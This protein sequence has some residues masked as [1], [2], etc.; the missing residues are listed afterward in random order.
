[1]TL[2][3]LARGPLLQASLIILVAGVIW[4]L[5][6]LV[7]LP[8]GRDHS[9]P[10]SRNLLGGAVYTI[11]RRLWP[12]REFQSR[13]LF[14][15]VMGYISH[16]GLALVVLGYRPHILFIRDLTG[17]SWPALPNPAVYVIGAITLAAFIALLIRRL[18]NGVLRLL[19]SADD[20]FSWLVTVLPLVTGYLATAHLGARY[21]TLLAVHLLSVELFLIWL[22]FGK[23]MHAFTFVLSRGFLGA[24]TARKGA[25][26]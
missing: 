11:L 16:I 7:I 5:T 13:V 25:G 23:L 1:M 24:R 3:E 26:A 12:H 8:Y 15:Y 9:E 20:Y 14:A 4:R 2:L 19:S 6:A 21:E 17:V 22:P 18:G 10:R